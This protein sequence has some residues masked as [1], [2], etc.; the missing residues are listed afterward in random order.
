M[1]KR[2]NYLRC[3]GH[4]NLQQIA[5]IKSK[6]TEISLQKGDYFSGAGKIAKQQVGFHTNDVRLYFEM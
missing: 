3:L 6:A 1:D 2:I 4:L 5:L